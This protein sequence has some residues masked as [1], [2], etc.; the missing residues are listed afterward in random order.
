MFPSSSSIVSPFI[1]KIEEE[2]FLLGQIPRQTGSIVAQFTITR[3]FFRVTSPRF[4]LPRS[5]H[6]HIHTRTRARRSTCYRSR[7]ERSQ[8]VGD[9]RGGGGNARSWMGGWSD[10]LSTLGAVRVS[11]QS[12]ARLL[13]DTLCSHY[14]HKVAGGSSSCLSNVENRV[15]RVPCLVESGREKIFSGWRKRC[16]VFFFFFFNRFYSWYI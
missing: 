9:D 2:R 11:Q 12:E 7:E 1:P 3:V 15:A 13:L 4:P 6:R 14:F 5:P 16:N 10:D 8:P